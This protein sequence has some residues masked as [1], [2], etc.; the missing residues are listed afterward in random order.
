MA[1]GPQGVRRMHE[2]VRRRLSPVLTASCLLR[3][4]QWVFAATISLI[5]VPGGTSRGF[6]TW[7]FARRH[8]GQLTFVAA[9]L[10]TFGCGETGTAPGLSEPASNAAGPAKSF[11]GKPS[12]E[13]QEGKAPKRGRGATRNVKGVEP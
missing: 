4:L 13:V 12:K 9:L 10:V 11:A 5:A 3:T 2:S 7:R 6:L 1:P 8:W